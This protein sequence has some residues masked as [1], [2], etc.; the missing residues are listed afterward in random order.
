M[1]GGTQVLQPDPDRARLVA[2]VA[3]R[4]SFTE[5]GREQREGPFRDGSQLLQSPQ[6]KLPNHT[7]PWGS[8][9]TP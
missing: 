7:E 8:I 3:S 1:K 6:P 4:F 5:A 2:F 9:V